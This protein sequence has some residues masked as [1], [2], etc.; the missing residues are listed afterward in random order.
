MNGI[1][2][3]Y[4][5]EGISSF[6]AVKKVSRIFGIKKA[7][8]TG[9]LDPLAEGVLPVCLGNA[10]RFAE[11]LTGEEKEYIAAFKLG[12]ST[13]SYDTTGE[14]LKENKNI[15]PSEEQVEKELMKFL[16]KVELP[17]PAY[18]AVKINGERAY[19]L[20]R[21]GEIE[22]AGV[23]TMEI[24][25]VELLDYT[26]PDGLV[27]IGCAKGTYIRSIV[28]VLGERLGTYASMSGLVRTKNGFFTKPESFTLEQLEELAEKGELEKAVTKAEDALDWGRAVVDDNAVRLICNGVSIN[29]NNYKSLP[30]GNHLHVFIMSPEGKLLAIGKDTADV[31]VPYKTIKVMSGA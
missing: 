3:L 20:A 24:H 27:R 9:T 19:K 14:V 1:V 31:E 26:Y 11:Y 30:G 8:H 25:S 21:K 13:D 10:T 12:F 5:P 17:I 29:R 15:I 28:H 4:K 6:I 2:N 16:G 18:S 7:G 22:D 23:R